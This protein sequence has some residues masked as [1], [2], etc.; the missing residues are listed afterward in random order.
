MVMNSLLK[1]NDE[2]VVMHPMYQSLTEHCHTLG[3]K[4]KFWNCKIKENEIVFDVDELKELIT[5][6]T[7]LL[8]VN[9]PHNPTGFVPNDREFQEI[10][11]LCKKND[12][13]I[14]SDEMYRGLW[15]TD[16]RLP[17]MCESYENS[18][19]L[20]GMSKTF[21]MPGARIGWLITR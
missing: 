11:T 9:F 1:K 13:T 10:I 21:S 8:V 14:F 7:R 18:V 17:S 12:V 5:T 16:Y 20:C 19:T 6:R 15:T 3:C 2:V 4:T